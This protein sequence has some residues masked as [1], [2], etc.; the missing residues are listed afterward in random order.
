MI[1]VAV[2]L[3]W[4]RHH[5]VG[6]T[7]SYIRNIL[8]GIIENSPKDIEFFLILAKDN[9][10]Y[11][12][13]YENDYIHSF[14]CNVESEN[15]LNRIIWQNILMGSFLRR[16]H[17]HVLFEPVYSTPF[18]GMSKLKI[19]TTIHDLQALHYPKYFSFLKKIWMNIEWNNAIKKSIKVV[20]ISDFVRDD[21]ISKLKS[22]P[23]KIVRIY[24]SIDIDYN[25]YASNSELK[26][27]GVEEKS[28]Y[29]TVSSLLPHKNLKTLVLAIAELH[30]KESD[31]FFPLII[32]GVG[33]KDKQSIYNLA[34][35]RGIS[36]Y[37]IITPFVDNDERNMLYKNCKAFLFPSIFEG[38]GMPPV[39]AMVMEVPVITTKCTSLEEV[40]NGMVNYVDEPMDV[41]NW[42]NAIEQV[43]IIAKNQKKFVIDKY[44]NKKI[45]LSYLDLF[46]E[47]YTD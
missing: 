23:E 44:S 14:I 2:D 28:Y 40:T 18:M 24:N 38:F 7:E 33:G 1:K 11:F 10:C 19:V 31:K 17:I 5:K 9:A 35:K 41:D 26:K 8:K 29:Y 42:V 34:K 36:D 25:K 43:G 6:G 47:V 46:R 21:I 45:G 22:N 13:M 37:I 30:K 16:K 39:E 15:I 4:C 3:T 32:S 20:A 27:Y 12:K